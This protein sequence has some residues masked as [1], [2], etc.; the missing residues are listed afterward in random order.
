MTKRQQSD[1]DN[2][3]TTR[4]RSNATKQRQHD[5]TTT[6]QK[7]KHTGEHINPGRDIGYAWESLR[8]LAP[9]RAYQS[10]CRQWTRTEVGDNNRTRASI[11]APVNLTGTH[12]HRG[13]NRKRTSIPRP[14]NFRHAQ[15][16][17]KIITYGRAF[18]GQ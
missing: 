17:V 11:S 18:L 4:Q 14:V 16:S 8:T 5:E 9:G 7:V 15:E 1:D 10:R 2:N 3:A 12:E 13:K 6:R